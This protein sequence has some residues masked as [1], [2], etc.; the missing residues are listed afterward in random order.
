[1]TQGRDRFHESG[2]RDSTLQPPR[3]LG[4][5][6]VYQ[7]PAKNRATGRFARFL[8]NFRWWLWVALAFVGLLV[9]GSKLD[10]PETDWRDAEYCANVYAGKVPDYRG[11]YAAK[12]SN[13]SVKR[14][15]RQ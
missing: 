1:M 15:N 5:L 2:W 6:P 7:R 9:V 10:Q 8:A 12:C 4:R 14:A 11:E 3:N 13:G